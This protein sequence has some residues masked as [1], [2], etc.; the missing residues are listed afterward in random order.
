MT[1]CSLA[2][3]GQTLQFPVVWLLPSAGKVERSKTIDVF[4]FRRS[5]VTRRRCLGSLSDFGSY[6]GGSVALGSTVKI[7]H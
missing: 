4:C 3:C 5:F 6:S 2:L 1:A 7:S